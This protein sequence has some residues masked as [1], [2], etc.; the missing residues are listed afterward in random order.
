MAYIY[1]ITFVAAP[2]QEVDFMKWLRSEALPKLFNA[3]SPAREPRIQTVIE[4]GGEKPGPDH[5]ISVALQAQFYS[6]QE[7]HA[8]NDNILPGA[9]AGFHKQFGPHAAFFVTLLQ[10]L[11]L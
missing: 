1:N 3:E 9:L 4:A 11:P 8:W 7:A 10:T 2:S 6:E 5:G